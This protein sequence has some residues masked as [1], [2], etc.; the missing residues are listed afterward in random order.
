MLY[1][2]RLRLTFDYP[3]AASGS[4]QRACLRLPDIAG[5]QRVVRDSLAIEPRPD[6]RREVA[7]F[8]GNRITDFAHHGAVRRIRLTLETRVERLAPGPAPPSLPRA[9]LAGVLA[10]SRDLGAEAPLHFLAPS[11]RVPLAAVMTRFARTHASPARTVEE[12]V[13]AVGRAL[14]RRMRFDAASTDVDT[15]A[16]EAFAQRAGVCQDF[17]HIM[18]ACLRGIGI[19][20][21]YVSGFLRTRP[22]PGRPR[23]EG[24]DA[25]HAWVRAW[26]GPEAGWIGFDPTNDCMAGASHV[27]VA[28]GRDYSDVAPI[29][30][31]FRIAGGQTSRQAVDVV[32]VEETAPG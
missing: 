31:S 18:I 20:A 12:A 26:A 21:G 13:V 15:P 24:A 4:R 28:H 17:S 7:D 19:P 16:A 8:F 14:H 2:I 27:T 10:A 22:P 23:L 3:G 25:M 9:D 30:G 11:A 1:D 29:R 5:V 32:P 6:E